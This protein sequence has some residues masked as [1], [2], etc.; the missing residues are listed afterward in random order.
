MIEICK[1]PEWVRALSV[2][3]DDLVR[4]GVVVGRAP[5]RA[6]EGMRFEAS[7]TPEPTPTHSQARRAVLCGVGIMG[8][9]A[10]VGVE[11]TPTVRLGETGKRDFDGVA[12]LGRTK[13]PGPDWRSG[14]ASAAILVV[15]DCERTEVV[16]TKVLELVPDSG[17]LAQAFTSAA[18]RFARTKLG[19]EIAASLT[20]PEARALQSAVAAHMKSSMALAAREFALIEG[21]LSAGVPGGVPL[22]D[23]VTQV[24]DAAQRR[25]IEHF[26]GAGSGGF[27]FSRASQT[28]AVLREVMRVLRCGGG[29]VDPPVPDRGL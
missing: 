15:S 29:F 16:A 5:W 3:T 19:R 25:V 1:D 17:R 13:G 24:E 26:L 22:G 8:I 10:D 23:L 27:S 6:S 11:P 9:L 4:R 20:S 14:V 28:L 2:E 21:L 18:R 7:L 12:D